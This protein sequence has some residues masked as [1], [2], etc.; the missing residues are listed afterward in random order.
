MSSS[1]VIPV[2][3]ILKS[4]SALVRHAAV[5]LRERLV[6][7]NSRNLIFDLTG[8]TSASRAFT[9]ELMLILEE[10]RSSGSDVEL[11]NVP[12][13]I[14]DMF[15]AI[16]NLGEARVSDSEHVPRPDLLPRHITPQEFD[17]LLWID[18]EVST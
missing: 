18:D 8:F 14:Q 11:I 9:H 6:L 12:R 5:A 7:E 15:A 4:S 2:A 10:T 17:E 16:S 3:E 1:V 13:D